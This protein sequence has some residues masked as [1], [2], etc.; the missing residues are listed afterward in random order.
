MIFGIKNCPFCGGA[1]D[2]WQTDQDFWVRCT[3]VDCAIEQNKFYDSEE[4]AIE[5]WNRRVK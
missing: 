2:V 5:A 1:S 4:E 3:N